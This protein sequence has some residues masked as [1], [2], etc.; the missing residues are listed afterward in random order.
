MGDLSEMRINNKQISI[1]VFLLL[2]M[3]F[4][5]SKY[6]YEYLERTHP[7]SMF[8]RRDRITK[9]FEENI[10]GKWVKFEAYKYK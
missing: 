1:V 9:Q 4:I 7:D 6:R 3:L 2:I 8:L 10:D 5:N